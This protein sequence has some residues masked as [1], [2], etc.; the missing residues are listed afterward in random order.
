MTVRVTLESEAE[1]MVRELFGGGCVHQRRGIAVECLGEFGNDRWPQ[2]N[3][4]FAALHAGRM[5]AGANGEL[6]L[7]EHSLRSP[8]AERGH[9]C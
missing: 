1:A 4:H 3:T 9:A 5:H 6:D 8:E 7:A 2:R